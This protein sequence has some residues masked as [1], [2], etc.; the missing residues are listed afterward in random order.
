MEASEACRLLMRRPWLWSGRDDAAIE[1]VHRF[2]DEVRSLV[3]DLQWRL[4]VEPD[5]VRLSKS[6]PLRS[7]ERLL[8]EASVCLW[9]WLC[10]AAI[11]QLPFVTRTA[12]LVSGAR[13]VAGEAEIVCTGSLEELR[14]LRCG[15]EMLCERGVVEV[16]DG[17]LEELEDPDVSALLKLRHDRML[18]LVANAGPL[19]ADGTWMVDPL[20][21][22][23]EW[24]EGCAA[25]AGTGARV[26]RR[27]VDDTVV[28]WAD[29]SL[30][31]AH[32]L[33]T[34][35]DGKVA[36]VAEALGMWVEERAEGVALVLD[37]EHAALQGHSFP[38]RGT[39]QHAAV[40]TRDYV[41]ASGRTDGAGCPGPGWR[42]VAAESVGEQLARWARTHR[43]W[44]DAYRFNIPLLVLEV[45]KF[46]T[47]LG[48]LRVACGYIDTW[49]LSPATARWAGPCPMVSATNEN[50]GRVGT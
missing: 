40:L 14:R 34:Q 22:P 35:L 28:H 8:F 27:L 32:W 49:W 23:R 6:P 39:L 26:L 24:I 33:R 1:A 12:D 10:V 20:A 16:L 3:R 7:G 41:L 15:I 50:E 29:L 13:E 21:E 47:R 36:E 31:E 2:E 48:L 4:V 11:E 37:G 18:W 25:E 19:H 30:P 17:T 44:S 5:T 45:R 42:A 46:W 9:M 38:Q 43:W